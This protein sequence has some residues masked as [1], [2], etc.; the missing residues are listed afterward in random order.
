MRPDFEKPY[1][2]ERPLVADVESLEH[3]T[4]GSRREGHY[5]DEDLI[6]MLQEKLRGKRYSNQ[7]DT[8]AARPAS[9]GPAEE[10]KYEPQRLSRKICW[11]YDS[12]A[13]RVPILRRPYI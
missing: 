3:A 9:A 12:H 5:R 6:Y 10:D 8:P 11:Q 2:E 7:Q 4:A 1:L 13:K